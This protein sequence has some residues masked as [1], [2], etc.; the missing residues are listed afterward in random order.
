MLNGAAYQDDD[1]HDMPSQM[2]YC[3]NMEFHF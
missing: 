1:E 2:Q 3:K